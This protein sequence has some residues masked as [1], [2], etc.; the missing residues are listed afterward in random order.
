MLLLS[1]ASPVQV[2]S[3]NRDGWDWLLYGFALVASAVALI[4]FVSW[5]V[6]QNKRPE[7]WF[8]WADSSRETW[9]S[10]HVVELPLNQEVELRVALLNVGRASG[11]PTM[12]NLVVPDFV[13]ITRLHRDGSR[14]KQLESENAIAGVATRGNKVNFLDDSISMAPDMYWLYPFLLT[15]TQQPE[16]EGPFTIL[17]EL[18]NDRFNARGRR[19]LPS[20]FG[21]K[22]PGWEP[23]TQWPGTRLSLKA[24]LR[25]WDRWRR[26]VAHPQGRIRCESGT[27]S[28][29]R[30]F[31]VITP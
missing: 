8:S 5:L 31:E 15:V 4:S 19:R 1:A 21:Y 29:I 11:P 6:E 26:V 16:S 22:L 23:G 10:D 9:A 27:R 12:I 20:H 24:R 30:Q 7:L 25:F 3:Q 2:V 14:K 17:A 28:D 18:S 13:Q